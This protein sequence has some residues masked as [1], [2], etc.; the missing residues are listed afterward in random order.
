[1]SHLASKNASFSAN[2]DDMGH[3]ATSDAYILYLCRWG[4]IFEKMGAQMLL[5]CW[6]WCSK[7]PLTASN[8][9]IIWLYITCQRYP[10]SP[11]PHRY[12]TRCLIYHWNS[13][14]NCHCGG[15]AATMTSTALAA[16]SLDRCRRC[17]RIIPRSHPPPDRCFVN[18]ESLLRFLYL[19]LH[20]NLTSIWDA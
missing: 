3:G 5:W 10:H 18:L 7:P 12:P 11:S 20:E 8:I 19:F 4:W 2:E 16:A 9:H 15:I 13:S 14:Q 6:C 1:M 17:I